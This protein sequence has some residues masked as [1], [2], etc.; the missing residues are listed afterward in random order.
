MLEAQQASYQLQSYMPKRCSGVDL[1]VNHS[2]QSARSR[3]PIADATLVQQTAR[4][5]VPL[6]IQHT[7]ATTG[8]LHVYCLGRTVTDPACIHFPADAAG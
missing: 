1:N 4:A 7:A 6:A 2:A 3:L 5:A 8:T